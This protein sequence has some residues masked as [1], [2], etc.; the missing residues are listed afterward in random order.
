MT[1]PYSVD[2]DSGSI[3]SSEMMFLVIPHFISEKGIQLLRNNTQ[4]YLPCMIYF[5]VQVSLPKGWHNFHFDVLFFCRFGFATG[6]V[7]AKILI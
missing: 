2:D 5:F 4:T 1:M 3:W 6:F 7:Q